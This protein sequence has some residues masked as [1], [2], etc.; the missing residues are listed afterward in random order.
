MIPISK[1]E[2]TSLDWKDVEIEDFDSIVS[3]STIIGGLI[4]S[5]PGE[6]RTILFL[7]KPDGKMIAVD[8]ATDYYDVI[9]SGTDPAWITIAEIESKR[10]QWQTG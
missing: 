5:L 6:G 10:S 2:Y 1:N 3:G 7:H 4:F 8:I 9:D